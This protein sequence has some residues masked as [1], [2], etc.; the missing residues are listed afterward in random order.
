MKFL[1]SGQFWAGMAVMYVLLL[2]FPQL[3]VRSMAGKKG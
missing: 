1:T 2:V 3:S